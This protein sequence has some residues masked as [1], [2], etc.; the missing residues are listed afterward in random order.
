[1]TEREDPDVRHKRIF[2]LI[3]PIYGWLNGY[4]RSHFRDA[5]KTVNSIAKVEG[6]NVL[7]IGTGTGAW[8]SLF[9]EKGANYVH[10]LDFAEKMIDVANNR[11]GSS[12]EFSLADAQNL[13]DFKDN[14]FDIVTAS[15]VL[16]GVKKD[17]REKILNEM[18]R[19]TRDLVVIHDYYGHSGPVVQFLERLEKSDYIY[20]KGN[21]YKELS[22]FFPHVQKEVVTNGRAIYFGSQSPIIS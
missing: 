19:I 7:D 10:G 22:E 2:N 3:A 20:F 21:F 4:V 18:K 8:A 11:Y 12:V 15:F 16:H 13:P 14:S 5:I 9:V 17:K 6:K 1:M